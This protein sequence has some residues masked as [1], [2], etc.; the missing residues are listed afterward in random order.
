MVVV[1][2]DPPAVHVDIGPSQSGPVRVAHRGEREIRVS[3]FDAE[4]H[5]QRVFDERAM[6]EY[7]Q[8]GVVI[9]FMGP[10]IHG[11]HAADTGMFVGFGA[12]IHLAA[13]APAPRVEVLREIGLQVCAGSAFEFTEMP[14]AQPF[15][16]M[17]FGYSLSAKACAV[18]IERSRSED[19]TSWCRDGSGSTYS[20]ISDCADWFTCHSPTS[21]SGMS[22]DPCTS[23]CVCCMR[24]GHGVRTV[25]FVRRHSSVSA[26]L[27]LMP[28]L[29]GCSS[30][31]STGS[32]SRHRRSRL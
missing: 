29:S 21:S 18:C 31:R 30:S 26:S 27:D 22:I 12:M 24:C 9:A 5:L 8:V 4:Q 3:S 19:T 17:H 13:H 7:E 14:L 1:L 23:P 20:L 11:L 16:G 25:P 10:I 32:Q 6:G 28:R 15:V 2:H